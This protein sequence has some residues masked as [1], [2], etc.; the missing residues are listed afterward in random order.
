[1]AIR[2]SWFAL[3]LAAGAVAAAGV[4]R[5]ETYH[6]TGR[7][8]GSNIVYVVPAGEGIYGRMLMSD[9]EIRAYH[10]RAFGPMTRAERARFDREHRELVEA[11]ARERNV[12]FYDDNAIGGGGRLIPPGNGG[13]I[14]LGTSNGGSPR[15]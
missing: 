15:R 3:G 9:D 12:T 4:A 11:R 13:A 10:E 6:P 1:M 14:G 7:D 5:A 8:L 2:K